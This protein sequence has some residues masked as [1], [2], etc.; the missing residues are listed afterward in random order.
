MCGIAGV[1]ADPGISIERQRL[2]TMTDVITHRG[3]DD[4]GIWISPEGNVGLGH[5]RLSIID[6]SSLGAQ[7]MLSASGRYAVAF[8]GEIYNFPDLRREL[9]AAGFQFRGHSDT[10]VMLAAFESWGIEATLQRLTGMFAFGV[11][12]AHE[13]ALWLARDRIGIKP[14]Y[15]STSSGQLTFASELRALVVWQ[16][17]VPGVSAQGLTDYLRLGYVPGPLSIFE[18]IYKLPPGHYAVYRH[19]VLSEAKAY[20][21]LSRVIQQGMRES[22]ADSQNAIDALEE[23]LRI[24]VASHM[25][26]DVPLGAFLSGGVDSSTVVALMQTQ[27]SRPIK[28]FSIGFHEQGYNEAEHAKAVA[29]HLGTEHTELYVSDADARA[30]IPQLPDVYDEPFADPSQIPTLLVSQLARHHVTVALSG[31]GGDELFAGYNRYVFVAQFWQRLKRLPLAVR[32]LA[33]HALSTFSPAAWDAFFQAASPFLPPRFLPALPGQKMHKIASILPAR[34]LLALH[35]R[36]IAQWATPQ[37]V[38][39]SQWLNNTLSGEH[40]LAQQVDLSAA[41]QQMAW[42]AQTYLV[43]DILTKVDRASMRFGLEARVPLLDH[44]VV[45]FAWRIPMSMKLKDGNGKWILRQ[46]LYRHVP[47]ELIDRPKMG[48]SVPVDEWLRGSLRGWAENYL[49]EKRLNEEGYLDTRVVR[50]TWEQHLKGRVNA[51]GQLWTLLMFQT[52]LEKAKTWV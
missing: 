22:Y 3:P 14:L 1:V 30:I 15:Y 25:I 42:D 18:S 36:L 23:K 26:A 35:S 12:D 45:E 2:A 40:R 52:W 9:E 51:G 8:N 7:P 31:D 33:S 29:R 48:F 13:Q 37:A 46:L 17:T 20:W 19:G 5:R 4:S 41:E 24:A 47:K 34:T 16:G 44:N 11:W 6:L 28:T 32:K 50:Q 39:G 10:E 38:L 21:Q 27:S 43:D 49:T